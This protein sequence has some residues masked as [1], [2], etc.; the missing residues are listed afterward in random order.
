MCRAWRKELFVSKDS[1]DQHWL[2]GLIFVRDIIFS[3]FAMDAMN[4]WVCRKC[5]CGNMIYV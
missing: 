1:R 2:L 5:V 3:H 4:L